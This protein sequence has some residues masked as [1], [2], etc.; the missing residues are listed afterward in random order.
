MDM[1]AIIGAVVEVEKRSPHE[2]EY[3]EQ[4]RFERRYRD[5]EF[6]DDVN[7]GKRL[8]RE[9]MIKARRLEMESFPENGGL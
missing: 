5:I 9:E 2:D 1:S 4:M 6:E 3:E 8:P 7:V